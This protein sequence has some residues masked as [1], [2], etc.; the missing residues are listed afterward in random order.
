MWSRASSKVCAVAKYA[1]ASASSAGMSSASVRSRRIACIPASSDGCRQ[2]RNFR[3]SAA[4]IRWIVPRM[5]VARTT[6][7]LFTAV[8]RSAREKSWRRDHNPVN[9]GLGSCACR[10]SR[11]STAFTTGR[12][13]RASSIWR[14]SVARLSSR[15]VIVGIL[16]TEAQRAQSIFATEAQ[17]SLSVSLEVALQN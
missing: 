7:R 8:D 1:R 17:R 2:P 15:S 6:V 13:S 16:A 3:K 12:F 9:G 5:D 4:V 11:C 14:A 10:P